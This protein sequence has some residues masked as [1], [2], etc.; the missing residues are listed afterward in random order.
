M[1]TNGTE[2]YRLEASGA[3]HLVAAGIFAPFVI[4]RLKPGQ[5][6]TEA[7]L[8]VR[9]RLEEGQEE[10]RRTVLLVWAPESAPELPLAVQDHIITE[11]AAL[12]IACAVLFRYGALRLRAVAARGDRFDYFV[13]DG[14]QDY[15]L[16]VSGTM[17]GDLEALHQEKLRQ[18]RDNPYGLDGYVIVV[19][20]SPAAVLFTFHRFRGDE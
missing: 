7:T 13:T 11:W 17:T 8:D 2:S 18:L 10:V 19:G 6:R 5:G 14:V 12:G 3:D 20:F 15:G 1:T 9:M 4:S 16:E